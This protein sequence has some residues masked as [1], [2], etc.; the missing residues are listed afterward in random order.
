MPTLLS[1]LGLDVEK[2]RS[3]AL[4]LSRNQNSKTGNTK[5]LTSQGL[6]TLT[7]NANQDRNSFI[8]LTPSLLVSHTS[9]QVLGSSNHNVDAYSPVLNHSASF[10]EASSSDD[11]MSEADNSS[12]KKTAS[13][14]Y[15]FQATTEEDISIVEGEI[16]V[17]KEEEDN[18][19]CW[20]VNSKGDEGYFPSSYVQL[21]SRPSTPG[22]VTSATSIP[23]LYTQ[24]STTSAQSRCLKVRSICAYDA[25]EN[26]ELSFPE[27]ILIQVVSKEDEDW[28]TGTFNGNTGVFPAV[29]VAENEDLTSG[30]SNS[31]SRDSSVSEPTVSLF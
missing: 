14:L 13:V 15:S 17:I 6:A 25:A 4:D 7:N 9:G 18:G 31:T 8:D 11:E 26:D 1:N 27:G 28:W 3:S 22:S 19:W 2:S 16:V 23:S 5:T 30:R 20:G 12:A 24:G 10:M 29:A 21:V